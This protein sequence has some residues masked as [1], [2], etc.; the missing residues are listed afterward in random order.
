MRFTSAKEQTGVET[1]VSTPYDVASHLAY[2]KGFLTLKE[3]T[4]YVVNN[5][6]TGF[7]P[8]PTKYAQY[9]TAWNFLG[10]SRTQYFTNRS[11]ILIASRNQEAINLK[12]RETKARR[13][14]ERLQAQLSQ[15]E[16]ELVV[17]TKEEINVFTPEQVIDILVESDA[18][19]EYIAQFIKSQKVTDA[20]AVKILLNLL[21]SKVK[22]PTAVWPW[23][24]PL[25]KWRGE[26][27]DKNL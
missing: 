2:S 27:L 18:S 10:T 6:M 7:K 1:K 13:K 19:T 21:S 26:K 15:Q 22:M 12:T 16:L 14:A 9:T 24:S 4:D 20:Y 11:L 25:Q 5:K 3:Y 23:T 17:P 8:D